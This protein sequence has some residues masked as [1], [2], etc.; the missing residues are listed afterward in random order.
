MLSSVRFAF[1]FRFKLAYNQNSLAH[2]T[3]GNESP[4]R[5]ASCSRSAKFQ[6]VDP[7]VPPCTFP[8]GT[9]F[10]ID[11][12]GLYPWVKVDL[13]YSDDCSPYPPAMQRGTTGLSPSAVQEF[14]EYSY[15]PRI[16]RTH[17]KKRVAWPTTQSHRFRSPLL[18][19]SLLIHTYRV[20]RWFNS[21]DRRV[22][23]RKNPFAKA[24]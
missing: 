9:L 13:H 17:P 15:P 11:N 3:K 20:L 16:L 1:I 8:Y 12:L 14:H 23:Q 7:W 2:Y 21:P 10:T 18:T 4:H 5:D 24:L 6:T 22:L 19:A